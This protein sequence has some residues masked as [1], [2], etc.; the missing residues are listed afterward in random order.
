MKTKQSCSQSLNKQ[1]VKRFCK[2]KAA[3]LGLLFMIVLIG[4]AIFANQLFDYNATVIKVNIQNRLQAPSLQHWMGTDDYGRD[5]FARIVHGA[6][7]SLTIGFAAVAISLAAGGLIGL[8]SAYYGGIVDDIL[9]RATDILMAIPMTLSC[10][11]LVATLGSSITNLIIALAIASIPSFARIVR[12]AV[13][14]VRDEE[15]IVSARALGVTDKRIIL[16]HVLPNC[17]GPILVQITLRIA[18]TIYNTSA[19]SFLGL[20]IA[21]PAPEWGGMLSA[22]RNYIRDYS[23][24]SVIPGLMIMVTILAL[25]LLGDGIRDALDPRLK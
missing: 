4:M 10:I 2:N 9:M 18:S 14:I 11:I 1:I 20:G 19:L 13:L 24:I 23:Y 3:V 7:T 22:G 16:R 25:N 8:F 12:S 5:I 6:R 21:Q 17:T 15:Y